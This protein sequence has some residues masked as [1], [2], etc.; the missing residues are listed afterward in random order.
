MSDTQTIDEIVTEDQ[1][2]VAVEALRSIQA[3]LTEVCKSFGLGEVSPADGLPPENLAVVKAHIGV[4]MFQAHN[5]LR[6]IEK[7]ESAR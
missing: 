7:M 5:A 2:D 3:R 1:R 4:M 6:N